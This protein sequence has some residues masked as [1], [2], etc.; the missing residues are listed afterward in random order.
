MRE[1]IKN[2]IVEAVE[3]CFRIK[4]SGFKVEVPREKEW[5]VSSGYREYYL[6]ISPR[7]QDLFGGKG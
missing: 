7:K 3:S 2:L 1:K 5:G 4:E 6:R